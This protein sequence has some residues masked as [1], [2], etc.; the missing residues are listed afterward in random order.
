MD[1]QDESVVANSRAGE[2]RFSGETRVF[3]NCLS[4]EANLL[5]LVRA[6]TS[7]VLLYEEISETLRM[8]P[9]LRGKSCRQLPCF[10]R[11]HIETQASQI[12][13]LF[14]VQSFRAVF[15]FPWS[16]AYRCFSP[17]ADFPHRPHSQVPLRERWRSCREGSQ[18]GPR[19]Q[20]I[21][22]FKGFLTRRG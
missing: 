17:N 14:S 15:K 18:L 16:P 12:G 6:A 2:D 22:P 5:R 3:L 20:Q 8:P 19:I 9:V 7:S 4:T 11:P 21:T 13:V 10:L 1:G